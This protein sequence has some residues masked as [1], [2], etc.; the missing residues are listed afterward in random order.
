MQGTG[1]NSHS[2]TPVHGSRESQG[3]QLALAHLCARHAA[4]QAFS[5]L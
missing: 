4:V 1:A 3:H 2:G 5:V